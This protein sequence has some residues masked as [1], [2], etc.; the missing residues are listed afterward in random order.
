MEVSGSHR[1]APPPV[2]LDGTWGLWSD[3]SKEEGGGVSILRHRE[4]SEGLA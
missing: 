4:V 3:P 1:H 2:L